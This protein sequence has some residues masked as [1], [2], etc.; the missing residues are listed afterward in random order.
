MQSFF[1]GTG[2]V[3]GSALPWIFSNVL[4]FDNTA[5]AGDIAE[6]IVASYYTGALIFFLAV[7]WTVFSTKEYP[8]EMLVDDSV[9]G[10]HTSPKQS[11]SNTGGYLLQGLVLGGVAVALALWFYFASLEK[12]LYIVSAVLAIFSVCYIVASIL[13]KNGREDI[14]F[15]HMVRDFNGMPTTMRQLVVVQFFT[16]FALFAMWIYTVPAVTAHI[17][18]TTDTKSVAYNEGADWVSVLFGVYN[19]V[20]AIVAWLLPIIARRSGRRI[21]H[22]LALMLGGIG[23]ISIYFITDPLWLIA[24]MIGIGIAWASILSMP[25]AILASSL[26]ANKMGYYMGIFNIFIV[27]PQIIAASILG[28]M[29]THFFNGHSIYAFLAGG[30]SMIVAGLLTLRVEDRDEVLNKPA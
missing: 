5:P 17:Y 7:M 15:V 11:V 24:S 27:L 25:Y 6:N 1:I 8:P 12:E 19:G 29:V 28:F 21:T 13:M 3:I 2:A 10:H 4:D 26:P 22:L 20:A 23:L 9:N 14:G 16:W 18:G 30:A